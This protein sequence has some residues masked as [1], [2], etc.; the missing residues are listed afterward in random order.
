MANPRILSADSLSKDGVKNSKGEDLGDIREIMIDLEHGRVAY[1]VLSFGGFMGLGD[2]LFAVP[3]SSMKL[4]TRDHKFVLD[5]PKERLERANGFD[6]DNWPD[7][8]DPS[9]HRD[10]YAHYGAKPYWS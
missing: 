6:K 7:F 3:W 4:D 10:T 1:A 5:V 9:F 8:A 2:K